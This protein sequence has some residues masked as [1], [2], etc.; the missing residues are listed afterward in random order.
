QDKVDEA[1]GHR[2][3]ALG[4]ERL[5]ADEGRRLV[6]GDGKAEARLEGRVVGGELASPCA[7]GLL[8]TERLDGVVPGVP[9][10]QIGT[11]LLERVVHT[12]RE[13]HGHVE[14]PAELAHVGDTRSA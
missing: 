6:E 10:P 4:E 11:R 8:D 7:I 12:G 5:A 1:P 14:L 9:E 13:L 2:A 3:S